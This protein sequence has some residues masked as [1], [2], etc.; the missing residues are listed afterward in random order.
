[1]KST[2]KKI[3]FI[4]NQ[5][6]DS[7][8]VEDT[9]RQAGISIQTYYLWTALPLQADFALIPMEPGRPNGEAARA[10]PT[11]GRPPRPR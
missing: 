4:L 7:V 6:D 3:A 2:E 5:A 8:S 11:A 9:C 1:M 10:H